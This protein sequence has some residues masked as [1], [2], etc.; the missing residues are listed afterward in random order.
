MQIL[1]NG[2]MDLNKLSIEDLKC[3]QQELNKNNEINNKN[4]EEKLEPLK[5]R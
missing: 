2:Y 3:L 5:I 1:I 4:N